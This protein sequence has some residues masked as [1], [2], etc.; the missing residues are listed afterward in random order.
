VRSINDNAK[1]EIEVFPMGCK[2][3]CRDECIGISMLAAC[4]FDVV[5]LAEGCARTL[6]G[7]AT[8]EKVVAEARCLAD[9]L[10]AANQVLS[11]SSM[12]TAA[13]MR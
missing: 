10:K 8:I 12:W 11:R 7:C 13:Q 1:R 9:T 3:F 2:G 5:T 4:Q 6:L